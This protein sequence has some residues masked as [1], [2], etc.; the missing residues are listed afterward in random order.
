MHFYNLHTHRKPQSAAEYAIR[1]AYAPAK[2]PQVAYALSV[3]LHPWSVQTDWPEK[4]EK[5]AG[6]AAFKQV[7]AIGE[8]GLDR[9][10]DTSIHL[11]MQALEAQVALANHVRKPLI[12]HAVRTY[13]DFP[14]FLRQL[15]LPAAFH[16]FRGNPT[17]VAQLSRFSVF[18]SFGKS[19]FQPNAHDKIRHIPPNRLLLETDTSAYNIADVYG[20]AAKLLGLDLADLAG[21]I[22]TNFMCFIG[23]DLSELRNGG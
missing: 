6:L 20:Q 14:F 9:H 17:Q 21:Q 5:V 18:F 15:Q 7:K 11:Q 8:V 23:G 12:F 13:A 16:D 10:I 2:L 19:L 3:G 1:N 22:E 4:V